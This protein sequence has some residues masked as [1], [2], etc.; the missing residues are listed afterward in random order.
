MHF[1]LSKKVKMRFYAFL[2]HFGRF[3]FQKKIK[4]FF[5]NLTQAIISYSMKGLFFESEC[6][7]D[8]DLKGYEARREGFMVS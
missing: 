4:N 5:D 8:M 1:S 3:L 2:A 7:N 6:W